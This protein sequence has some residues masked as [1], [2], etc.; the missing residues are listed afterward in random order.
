LRRG[1]V[2]GGARGV[3]RARK[4]DLSEAF[5][6][7]G[8]D[9]VARLAGRVPGAVRAAEQAAGPEPVI[10]ERVRLRICHVVCLLDLIG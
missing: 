3:R 1:G 8:F 6:R 9:D 5:S 7:S 10:D 4:T 2:S